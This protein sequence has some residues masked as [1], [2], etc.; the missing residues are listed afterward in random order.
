MTDYSLFSILPEAEST[1]NYAMASVQAGT[2]QHGMAWYTDTQTAGKGQRG[3][4]WQSEAK[5]N[6]ALSIA[7]Q[8]QPIFEQNPFLLNALLSVTI[9]QYLNTIIHPHQASIK[10]P[11]DIYINDRKAAGQL[12]ETMYRGG[13]WKWAVIGV[14]INVNQKYYKVQGL[15]AIS[16][17]DIQREKIN[18]ELLAKALYN[19]ILK[20][21]TAFQSGQEEHL[22]ETYNSLLFKRNEKVKLKKGSITFE[23]IIDRVSPFGRLETHDVIE[24][25]FEWG[26]VQWL[27]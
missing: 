27:L 7:V 11:N 12:I 9:V 13:R 1:N 18:V 21:I 6:L 2:A 22:F 25:S 20:N 16:L 4:A 14:G 8:P 3:K 24:R 23:T 17:Y 10:W 19:V 5:K 15:Q 26:H